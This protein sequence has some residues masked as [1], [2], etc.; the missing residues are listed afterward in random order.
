MGDYS[1]GDVQVLVLLRLQ[2]SPGFRVWV[3]RCRLEGLFDRRQG[4]QFGIWEFCGYRGS[5]LGQATKGS[6]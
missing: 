1:E 5:I 3:C 4:L 6:L 2:C